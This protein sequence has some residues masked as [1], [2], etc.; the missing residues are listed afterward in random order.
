M[1]SITTSQISDA[2]QEISPAE[3]AKR[4]APSVVAPTLNNMIA[5]EAN[6]AV[7]TKMARNKVRLALIST[8]L[9]VGC[10]CDS[11]KESQLHAALS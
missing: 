1:G 4:T 2:I 8:A 5:P 6:I 3:I 11:K 9:H 7:P 10:N